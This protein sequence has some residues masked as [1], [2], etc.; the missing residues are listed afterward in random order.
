MAHGAVQ[1]PTCVPPRQYEFAGH[2]PHSLFEMLVHGTV[3][4]MP[5]AHVAVQAIIDVPPLQ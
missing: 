1:V 5:W 3:S 4:T 2:A